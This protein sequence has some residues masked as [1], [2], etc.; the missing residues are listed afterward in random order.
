MEQPWSRVRVF[1]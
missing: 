1:A